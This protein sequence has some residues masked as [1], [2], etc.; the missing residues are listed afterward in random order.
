MK[1]H[2]LI[3]LLCVL[4]ACLWACNK[5]KND[6]PGQLIIDVSLIDSLGNNIFPDSTADN[7]ITP[8]NAL[9]SYWLDENGRKKV[10]SQTNGLTRFEGLRFI[11]KQQQSEVEDQSSYI[12]N[13]VL[14]WK[15]FFH[16]DSL[17]INVAIYHPT[18]RFDSPEYIVWKA[19]TFYLRA[20]NTNAIKVIY[21]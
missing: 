13:R 20:L 10:F 19:D 9:E 1:Q 4:F 18:W 8:F 17:P 15:V 5:Q 11:L 21:P 2:I 6:A 16:P 14:K 7:I 12:D 3:F